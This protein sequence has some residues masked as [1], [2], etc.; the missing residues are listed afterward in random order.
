MQRNQN[1]CQQPPPPRVTPSRIA[2]PKKSEQIRGCHQHQRK[3]KNCPEAKP[4]NCR[5]SCWRARRTQSS[6]SS[7]RR[8][9]LT[10]TPIRH[11][12]TPIP[13]QSLR[14]SY[15]QHN[16]TT[17][18]TYQNGG[19]TRQSQ[20]LTAPGGYTAY[21]MPAPRPQCAGNACGQC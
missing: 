2:A 17:Q 12:G 14:H 20:L 21:G 8:K 6:Q 7:P 1:R 15:L 13:H 16:M 10:G 18:T 4:D 9:I 3:A 19:K 11:N 5:C